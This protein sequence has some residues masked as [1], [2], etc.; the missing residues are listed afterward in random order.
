MFLEVEHRESQLVSSGVLH[1][2]LPFAGLRD[3]LQF[4]PVSSFNTREPESCGDHFNGIVAIAFSVT[5]PHHLW[6]CKSIYIWKW[7]TTYSC[8]TIWHSWTTAALD[9]DQHQRSLRLTVHCAHL[10]ID[11]ISGR[12]AIYSKKEWSAMSYF[13]KTSCIG[14]WSQNINVRHHHTVNNFSIVFVS[15]YIFILKNRIFLA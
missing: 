8:L 5:L 3:H 14:E 6:Y 4:V 11:N 13:A 9:R 7:S 12:S 2:Q 10:R 15:W 1:L